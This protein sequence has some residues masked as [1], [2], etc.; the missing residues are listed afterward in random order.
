[1]AARAVPTREAAVVN[2]IKT[3]KDSNGTEKKLSA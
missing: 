3:G 2:A 1:M